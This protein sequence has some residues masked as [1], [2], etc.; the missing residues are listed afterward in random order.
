[1]EA[2]AFNRGLE[3]IWQALDVANKYIV[4]TAPFTLAKEQAQLPRVAQILSN[5]TECLRVVAAALEP[6]MP[7]TSSRILDLLQV[8]ETTAA[9]PYGQGLKPGHKVKPAEPLFPRID[10]AKTG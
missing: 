2:L 5:L 3:A 9:Q 7:V 10:K 8:D 1:V 4:Q 6:F